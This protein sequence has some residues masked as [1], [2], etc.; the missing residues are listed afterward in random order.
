MDHFLTSRALESECRRGGEAGHYLCSDFCFC[1]SGF[2]VMGEGR[3]QKSDLM[4][5]ILTCCH[6]NEDL[7]VTVLCTADVCTA[8]VCTAD[9]GAD[10]VEEQTSAFLGLRKCQNG[11]RI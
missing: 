10:E 11:V 4:S 1:G 6:G 5:H 3:D 8:D 2:G 7:V 9:I